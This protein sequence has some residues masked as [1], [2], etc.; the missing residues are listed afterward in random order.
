MEV[1]MCIC[2]KTNSRVDFYTRGKFCMIARRLTACFLDDPFGVQSSMLD[3][4]SAVT[5]SLHLVI[6]HS[7]AAQMNDRQKRACISRESLQLGSVID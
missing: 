6:V 7:L 1:T 3:S 2:I 5:C 4:A